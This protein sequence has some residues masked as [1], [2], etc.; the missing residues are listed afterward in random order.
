MAIYLVGD[1][2]GCYVELQQVL[3][4][5]GFEAGNDELW[6]TGDLVA[7]GPDSLKTLRFLQS[8]G[9]SAKPVLGN[10]D[11]HLLAIWHGLQT[12]HPKDYLN[13]LLEAPDAAEL[14]DWLAAQP[15]LRKLPNAN[16]YMTHAGLA[17][18][19]DIDTAL[20]QAEFVHAC[21]RG[22]NRQYWLQNMYG[23]EPCNWEMATTELEKFRYSVNALTRMRYCTETGDLEFSHKE[24]PQHNPDNS[25]KPWFDLDESLTDSEWVIGHWATLEG[26]CPHP[27]IY[28]LDT[29]CVWGGDMTLLRWEDKKRFR[30]AST[31]TARH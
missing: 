17:P 23:N 15:L 1:V 31:R 11:L 6:L 24:H 20:I 21:I 26:E 2:Q 22:N 27:N 14:I 10:H 3:S 19:W 9:N 12:P 29:G 18:Q 30:V 16:A 4:Q 28:A 25:L 8:L 7:R 5:A 13:A